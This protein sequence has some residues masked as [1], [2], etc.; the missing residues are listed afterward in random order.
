VWGAPLR[1]SLCG[2]AADTHG[3]ECARWGGWAGRGPRTGTHYSC[4]GVRGAIFTS[5]IN[6]RYCDQRDAHYRN[7][8]K[9]DKRAEAEYA[10][11]GIDSKSNERRLLIALPLTRAISLDRMTKRRMDKAWT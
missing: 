11:Y 5:E 10:E 6:H 7:G 2:S 4:L 3:A 1:A 9:R 8:R